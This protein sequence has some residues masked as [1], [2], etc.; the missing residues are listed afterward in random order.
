[1]HRRLHRAAS[2]RADYIIVGGGSAGC[3]LANRLSKS[4]SVLLV[5]AGPSDRGK[6]DSWKMKM[7]AALTFNLADDKYNWAYKTVPQVHLDNRRLDWPRGRVLG[8]SSSLNAMVYIRGHAQD[9]D[10]WEAAGAKGWSYADVLPYFKRAQSHALGGDTYRGGDGPLHVSRGSQRDQVLF[11]AF[12]DAGVQ[13]GYPFTDDMNG[14]QQEGFGFMDSTIHNGVR[15]SSSAAYLHPVLHERK[16]RL[17]VVT[18]HLVHR[19]VVDDAG[20]AQGID[21]QPNRHSKSHD[22]DR[23]GLRHPDLQFHFLPGALTGQLT[24]G[25]QH[26]MQTHISPLRATSRGSLSLTTSNPRD[27]PR[28]DPNY[29]STTQDVDDIR[30]GVLLAQ[31]LFQQKAMD[32]FRGHPIS[33]A[34][35]FAAHEASAIDAWVRQHTESAYHPSCTNRMGHDTRSSV[36]NSKCQVHG[37]DRLRVVDASIMPNIISGNLNAPVIMMAEKA[38]DIILDIAPLPS[39]K[40]VPVY[41][42]PKWESSQR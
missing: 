14:F 4:N 2:K 16:D 25:S 5:E 19:V 31:E 34:T 8:G 23:P 21:V 18:D 38:A 33:P 32:P 12:I 24:P 28:L 15:W 11:Q 36:V 1:M 40:H 29:L 30:Q 3:V 10:D 26:A 37:V 35:L 42:A 27:P 9:Y 6:W 17:S 20:T 39:A 13:A 7:P 22:I 41:V